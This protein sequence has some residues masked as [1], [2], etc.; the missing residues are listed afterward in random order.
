MIRDRGA[1]TLQMAVLAPFFLLLI[2]VCFQAGLWYM[3]RNAALATAQEGLR[4]AR[5]HN[6]SLGQGKSAADSF[7]R[8]VAGGQLIAPQVQVSTTADQTIVVRVTGKVPSFVPGLTVSVVQEARAPKE[9]WTGE[10]RGFTNS[11][12]RSEPSRS[13]AGPGG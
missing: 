10:T 1:A 9:R 11:A 6:G 3:A 2:G 12:G 4:V 8:Q 13:G 7:A 5:A